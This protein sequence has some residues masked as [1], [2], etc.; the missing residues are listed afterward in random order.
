MQLS[1]LQK[2]L[3][4]LVP[5]RV[6]ATQS[7]QHARLELY[8]YRGRW[9]LATE[10]AF[11]SDGAAYSPLRKAFRALQKEVRQ[12]Q[13]VLVLGAGIG[14]AVMVLDKKHN[15]RPNITLVD[16]DEEILTLAGEILAAEG[17]AAHVELICENAETYVTLEERTFDAVVIDVFRGRE[18]PQFALQPFFL[19]NCLSR[20]RPGGRL[21]MNFIINSD[22]EWET[23]QQTLATVVPGY[24]TLAIGV[25][26][27]ILGQKFPENL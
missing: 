15:L 8:R 24:Q 20:L 13:D 21:I 17:H 22:R 4:Y 9:Q 18:V 10:D 23:F 11:Y 3:S 26:R 6:L 25:N 1:V 14:S 19:Q 2:A 7:P 16:L 12:W 27:I 5:V